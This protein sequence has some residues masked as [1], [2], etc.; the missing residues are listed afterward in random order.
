MSGV[1]VL[2]GVNLDL[3]F[4]ALH[5]S[6]QPGTSNPGRASVS[7]GGVGRNI[8]DHLAR[9][10]MPVTLI[11]AVGD[12]ALSAS[13]MSAT[14]AAGV[15]VER[16]RRVPDAVCG[17]YAALLDEGGDLSM[18]ASSMEAIAHVDAD[19][20]EQCEDVISGA[21]YLVV[22]ANV[23]TPALERAIA[24]ANAHGVPVVAEPVS[25]EKA[26]RIAACRGSV[27]A[28]TPNEHEA[29]VVLD[30]S[31]TLDAAWVVVTK[32]PAGVDIV[33]PRDSLGQPQA[34]LAGA[35]VAPVDVTGAGDAL[36][37]GLVYALYNGSELETGVH[38]GMELARET[39]LRS[40]SAPADI[41]RAFVAAAFARLQSR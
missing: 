38:L 17:L 34:T 16:V 10:G 3:T 30:P 25:V 13:V 2:G 14:R 21:A 36:V 37:A 6:M 1:C 28:V 5:G 4:R 11:A 33:R 35:P 9:W 7:P 39:V 20:V 32:G 15:D 23:D 8:A 31:S 18:A 27:L 40:G 41:D 26:A 22:D 29:P 24:I 19:Y 12:D